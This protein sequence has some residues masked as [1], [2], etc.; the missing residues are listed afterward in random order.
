LL[1]E[2]RDASGAFLHKPQGCA[3]ACG[4]GAENHDMWASGKIYFF[5]HEKIPLFHFIH[6]NS[7]EHGPS[8]E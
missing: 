7:K 8:I 2:N 3:Y 5:W 1:F 6:S 4:T